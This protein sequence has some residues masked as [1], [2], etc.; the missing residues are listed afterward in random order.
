MKKY[1]TK[2]KAIDLLLK[3]R[4]KSDLAANKGAV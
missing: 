2:L 3:L 1:S 4:P